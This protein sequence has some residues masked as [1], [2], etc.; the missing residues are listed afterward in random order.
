MLFHVFLFKIL[1][2][3][4]R[5]LGCWPGCLSLICSSAGNGLTLGTVASLSTPAPPSCPRSPKLGLC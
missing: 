1:L 3:E 4:K 2:Q 5:T